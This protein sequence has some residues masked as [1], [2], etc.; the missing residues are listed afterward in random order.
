MNQQL[1]TVKK[2]VEDMRIPL[3]HERLMQAVD[4]ALVA[5]MLS[6]RKEISFMEE[7]GIR[8]DLNAVLGETIL[9]VYDSPRVREVIEQL[10]Y[11]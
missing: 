1:E 6:D 8:K 5:R 9:T 10:R 11:C 4:I 3:S 2:Q 7:Q